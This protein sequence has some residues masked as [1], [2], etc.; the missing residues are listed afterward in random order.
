[1]NVSGLRQLQRVSR[2]SSLRA[3]EDEVKEENEAPSPTLRRGAMAL[4]RWLDEY[5]GA[6][7]AWVDVAQRGPR[8][9]WAPSITELTKTGLAELR[10]DGWKREMRITSLGRA[11]MA[12][13]ATCD[14]QG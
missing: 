4:L 9:T 13:S 12:R 7:H 2:A 5:S 6:M 10:R 8:T 11:L 3:K 14:P 1:M